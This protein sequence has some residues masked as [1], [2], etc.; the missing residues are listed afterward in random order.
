MKLPN[1]IANK[2]GRQI[3][4]L[5]ASSPQLM[6]VGGAA[7][8][9]AG[10]VLACKSTLKLSD[11]LGEFEELKEKSQYALENKV[12]DNEGNVYDEKTFAKDQ[13]V[14]RIK[15]VLA[16]SKLYAPA[17]GLLLLSASLMTGSHVTLTRRNAATA[18]AYASIDKAFGEYRE[19]VRTQL[20]RDVDD[21][22]RYGSKQVSETVEDQETGKKKVIKHTVVADGTPSMYA[23]F[24]DETCDNWVRNAE[25][26]KI[27]LQAQQSYF[28]QMLQARGHV[29]LNEVYDALGFERSQ[30]GQVVGWFLG[31]EGDNYV[32]FG[33]FD[34]P[35]NP[36]R[37]RAFVNGHENAILLDFNVDGVIYDKL[38]KSR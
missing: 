6:F 36:D 23:R 13:T 34:N 35:V 20:G 29:F 14:I 7:A 3:L 28:N 38:K 37:A 16:V 17:A 21:E 32:D 24:F 31:P 9:V 26:N 18:A 8:G 11:T 33:V 4:Q 10:V 2:F 5:K 12:V 30:E 27:F 1:G 22:M 25:Y 19:R 15:T